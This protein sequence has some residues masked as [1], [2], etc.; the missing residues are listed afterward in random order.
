MYNKKKITLISLIMVTISEITFASDKKTGLPQL[1]FNTYPSLIFWSI[2]S[3]VIG[4]ILMAYIVT[5]QI[6][7]IINLRETNIQNDLI[8]AKTSNEESEKIK[9]EV[10]S[11]QEEIK[12]SSQTLINDALLETK[13][14]L[15]ESEK[16][17]SE[18]MELRI[19]KAEQK[20]SETKDNVI[21]EILSNT[22]D[23]TVG[24]VQKFTDI[25]PIIND[26]KK[27]IDTVSKNI[28]MEK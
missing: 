7:S 14:L 28:V 11:N 19:S 2:I 20:I 18:K 27:T 3:L 25:K 23:L 5:P 1:D 26:I 8:K 6:K 24:I 15:E 9:N 4:Y 22:E 12:L 16:K 21:T 17:I 13:K 10:L